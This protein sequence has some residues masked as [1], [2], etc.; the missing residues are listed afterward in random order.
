MSFDYSSLPPSFYSTTSLSTTSSSA[1][2][3]SSKTRSK[4]RDRGIDPG[5]ASSVSSKERKHKS[6]HKSS[7]EKKD[8][9]SKKKKS[10]HHKKD[11]EDSSSPSSDID[12]MSKSFSMQSMGSSLSS[13]ATS[14]RAQLA[15]TAL[16]SGLVVGG[17]I[18]GYQSSKR[19]IRTQM[20]KESISHISDDDEGDEAME[21]SVDLSRFLAHS[22]TP[23]STFNSSTAGPPPYTLSPTSNSSLST[24]VPRNP[25]HDQS[26]NRPITDAE[27]AVLAQRAQSLAAAKKPIPEEL[28][29]EQLSRNHSFLGT[30][31]LRTIRSSFVV[32]VGLGGVGSWCATMLIRSG[33][34]RVRLIDFDQVTLSSL[35]RHA[36]ATLED[37]GTPKVLAMKK[38]LEAVAPWVEIEA[39][40]ELWTEKD[41]KRLLDGEPDWVVDAIDNIDT[42]VDLL[43]YCHGQG[44]PVI[45][46]MG[47]GC[48]SD[49]TRI[50]IGDISETTEDP[51]SKSTR[52]KLRQ[53]GIPTG[54]TVVYSTEKPGPGKAQLLPLSEEEHTKGSVS[55]LGVLENFRVR[56][57]PVLGTMPATFGLAA[58][59]HVLCKLA[60]YPLEYL[61][62]QTRFRPQFYGQVVNQ[63]V[64]VE[65]RI[66]NNL[67]GLKV[68]VS[69]ADAGYIVEEIFGGKS[70]I[71]GLG[72][73]LHLV[74]WYSPIGS[75]FDDGTTGE[76][77]NGEVDEMEIKKRMQKVGVGID[78]AIF[79]KLSDLVVMTKEEVKIHERRVLIGGESPVAV[80]GQEVQDL[81]EKKWKQEKAFSQWR[82]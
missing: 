64:A 9:D 31:G 52:R 62:G 68:P 18:L 32:I 30:Q 35:N 37:V 15:A 54:I 40:V 12:D 76:T 75:R 27:S 48:K 25:E 70:V 60:E 19:R 24:T 74:R 61:P 42:K 20:L 6:K 46:S 38:R 10:K 56:I 59:N 71:S 5:G 81:V 11:R 69:E 4:D 50:L 47:A 13:L 41:A 29:L 58:A 53:R 51:L 21:R 23:S 49:P 65:S 57:L 36:V 44:I 55:E 63:L 16:V 73:R 7:K 1:P 34:G 17:T 43:A 3:K 22:T 77:T 28:I 79:L 72:N 14:H 39:C 33:I 78:G 45:S 82:D 8:K 80:W 66:R 26:T 2:H 67:P